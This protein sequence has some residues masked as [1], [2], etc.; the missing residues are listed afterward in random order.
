MGVVGIS[1]G[2]FIVVMGEHS[3]VVY[4]VFRGIKKS[5]EQHPKPASKTSKTRPRSHS[6]S[7]PTPS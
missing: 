2:R 1:V 3:V 7:P 6:H 5:I 4:Y